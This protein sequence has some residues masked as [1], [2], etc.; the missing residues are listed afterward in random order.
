[1][2]YN[3]R[4]AKCQSELGSKKDIH[5]KLNKDNFI[6]ILTKNDFEKP[7]V[8]DTSY[9]PSLC[10]FLND[11]SVP[12]KIVMGAYGSGKTSGFVNAIL[13]DAILM[14]FCDDGVR[15]YKVALIRNTAGQLET[16]T[17]NTWLYWTQGLPSPYRNKKPQLTYSYSFRDKE[18][19]IKLDVIFLALDR[20]SDVSKL[21]SLEITSAYF[22]ELRHIPKKIFDAVMGRIRRYPPKLEFIQQFEEEYKDNSINERKKLLEKW[23]PYIPRVYADTNA[24][25]NNHWIAELEKKTL[26]NMKVYHQPPALIREKNGDWEVNENADNL[27][28]QSHEYYLDMIDRGEEYIKVYAQGLYGTVVDGKPVYPYYNDDL[29][30]IDDLPLIEYEP[31][32]IGCDYGIVAPAVLIAQFVKGQIRFLKEFI[33]EYETIT[34]IFKNSVIP[35][36]NLY[37]KGFTLDVVGDPADTAQGRAQ[38]RE[39]GIE[40]SPSSTNR[41]EARIMSVSNALNEMACGQAKIL[42]SRKG[43]PSLREGFLGEYHYRRLKVIGD[44]KYVDTPNKTHP[45]SDIHDAAQYIVIRLFD[46]SKIRNY[47]RESTYRRPTYADREKSKVTGY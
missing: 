47:E 21:D 22:N 27:A 30:S 14:P 25:K 40:A 34:D 26:K 29:H 9:V 46:E 37:C 15:R 38:L 6:E 17:L 11:D 33:G 18:G 39:L 2:T 43:C 19:E 36:L 4:L 7:V 5:V 3:Q 24:P 41:I 31:I 8:Y 28:W 42:V 1:M 10:S 45:Y 23:C 32:I 20:D 13:R 16:T 12:H 44:E 35:F